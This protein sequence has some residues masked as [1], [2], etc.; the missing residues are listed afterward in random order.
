MK[1][2][3]HSLKYVWNMQKPHDSLYM[4]ATTSLLS[5]YLSI[6]KYL[7]HNMHSPNENILCSKDK[8][9]AFLK[10]NFLANN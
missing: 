5:T 4:T 6:H 7:E 10:T 1:N 2:S 8:L 9:L 3:T